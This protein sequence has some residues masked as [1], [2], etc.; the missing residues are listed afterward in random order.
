MTWRWVLA[1]SSGPL[2]TARSSSAHCPGAS[3]AL[4]GTAAG[5][6]VTVTVTGVAGAGDE[7][8]GVAAVTVTVGAGAAEV[9]RSAEQPA[10][11]ATASRGSAISF[12]PK[13]RGRALGDFLEELV[14]W[15]T[16]RGRYRAGYGAGPRG[17]RKRAERRWWAAGVAGAS[18]QAVELRTAWF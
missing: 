13:A 11:T 10:R 2:V 1:D 15:D 3:G 9:V 5:V 7:G 16:R 6:V 4:C 18:G 17:R 14:R 12:M 8:K